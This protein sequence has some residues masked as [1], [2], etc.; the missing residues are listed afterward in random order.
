MTKLAV[1]IPA[2]GSGSR[3]GSRIPKP[4]LKLQNI[5]IL[6]HT[7]KNFANLDFVTQIIVST[8]K[9]W[10]SEVELILS[11]FSEKTETLSVVIGGNERQDS[12]NNALSVV[13]E[14]VNLVAVH[15]AVRP[16]INPELIK[17][18]S[19]SALEFG[20][21]IIAIPAKDTIKEVG[22]DLVIQNTPERNRLW[23]AQTPQIFQKNLLISAYTSAIKSGFIGTD[24]ASLVERIGGKVKII[25]G[26]RRNLKI[27]FPIDL[28][29]AELILDEK[30]V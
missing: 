27:T 30:G 17:Q 28:K 15:D 23:Q 19:S 2:A 16:F 20:G 18:C 11:N 24:D 12:I 5:S 10:V 1:I 4:F 29:V 22:E 9:E 6:E 8:S 13:S 3:M 26:D 21:A 14:D 7:I 25:E